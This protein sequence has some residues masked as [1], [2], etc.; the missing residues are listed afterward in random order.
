MKTNLICIL[1]DF[2]K[3]LENGSLLKSLFILLYNLFSFAHV[4]FVLSF[5]Y[6]TFTYLENYSKGS[7]IVIVTVAFLLT[8]MFGFFGFTLWQY[9]KKSLNAHIETSNEFIITPILAKFTNVLAENLAGFLLIYGI[10]LSLLMG[11]LGSDFEMFFT[12]SLFGLGLFSEHG[13]MGL[14]IFP[15]LGIGTIIVGRLLSEM[16]SVAVAIANNTGRHKK[17]ASE[18]Q[19]S[20]STSSEEESSEPTPSSEEPTTDN[21]EVKKT[22]NTNFTL[23]AEFAE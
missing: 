7:V 2:Y 14:V 8:L 19:I 5:L 6:I 1:D 15:L 12:L 9:R 20:E 17:T 4:A 16:M 22:I 18:V 3:K 13:L 10:G 21:H 11:V 23:S